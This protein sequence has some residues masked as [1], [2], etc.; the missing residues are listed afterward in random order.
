[1]KGEAGSS[2]DQ[3]VPP[4]KAALRSPADL[5]VIYAPRTGGCYHRDEKCCL[6]RGD[7]HKPLRRCR[8]CWPCDEQTVDPATPTLEE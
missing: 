7:K 1:M 8:S 3:Y 5:K 4:K 2:A 6:G